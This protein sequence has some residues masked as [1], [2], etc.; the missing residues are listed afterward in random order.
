MAPDAIMT[1]AGR[2]QGQ[3]PFPWEDGDPMEVL[4][5]PDDVL[6]DPDSSLT[7]QVIRRAFK[8]AKILYTL[9]LDSGC[10]L[11][12]LFPSHNDHAEGERVHIRLATDHLVAFSETTSCANART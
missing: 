4:I 3:N 2:L 12:S 10:Y 6:P 7:A 8:G 9:K 5:R 1:S 11:Q